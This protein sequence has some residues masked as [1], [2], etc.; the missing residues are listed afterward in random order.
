MLVETVL[1]N[2]NYGNY[3]MILLGTQALRSDAPTITA[4]AGFSLSIVPYKRMQNLV[5]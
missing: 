4:V 3:N 2:G 5:E 1:C